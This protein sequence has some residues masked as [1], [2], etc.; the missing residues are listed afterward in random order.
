MS[1]FNVGEFFRQKRLQ[2][3]INGQDP[4]Y[5]PDSN[6]AWME[7]AVKFPT[8][9]DV[10]ADISHPQTNI[11]TTVDPAVLQHI[12]SGGSDVIPATP[13]EAQGQ[14]QFPQ[15]TPEAAQAIGPT[16]PDQF[17]SPNIGPEEAAYRAQLGQT[18]LR[19]ND[20]PGM[21]R[22]IVGD[23]AGVGVGLH[24]SDP[25]QAMQTTE[26][27]TH[28]PYY[29]QLQNF[30]QGLDIQK[31][32]SELE[33][34]DVS[35]AATQSHLAAQTGAEEAR[36]QA[37]QARGEKFQ[38]DISDT[39]HKRKL[40]ELA[41]QHPG[42]NAFHEAK[43]KDGSLVYLKRDNQTG[44]LINTD[45]NLPVDMN[46]IEVLSDPNKSLKQTQDEKIPAALQASIKAREIVADPK[47]LGTPEYEAAQEYI[48]N[49]SQGKDPKTAFDAVKDKTNEERK[50]KGQAEMSSSELTSLAVKLGSIEKPPQLM[51]V[52]PNT[53]RAI[54]LRPGDVLPPG[55]TTPQQQ[56]QNTA[57]KQK[58]NEEMTADKDFVN[59][60]IQRGVYTGPD[61][62]ALLERFFNATKPS[63]GFRMNQSQIALLTNLRSLSSKIKAGAAHL[64]GGT[65]FDDKQRKEIANTINTIIDSKMKSSGNQVTAPSSSNDDWSVKVV[66]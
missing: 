29:Q 2:D 62:E 34:G 53:N 17:K 54:N 66:K 7:H 16:Q 35:R 39:A 61:D 47:K 20:H 4:S 13:Q 23:I 10:S 63:T 48:K 56:G 28:A 44:R 5:D 42:T 65:L 3:Q 46:A 21:L 45:T 59:G 22:R 18:P 55:A 32:K 6:T 33:T 26:Q 64:T 41:V 9:P 52:D 49:L 60:Y 24:T 12:Q 31:Q 40:E 36:R 8:T 30:N 14:V 50:A 57:K 38:Y 37:E 58:E 19:A 11:P 51:V 27:V 15:F 43:L 1:S 25:V